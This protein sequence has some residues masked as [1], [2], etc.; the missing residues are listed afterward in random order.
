MT[1]T[2]LHTNANLFDFNF[3]TAWRTTVISGTLPAFHYFKYFTNFPISSKD[4]KIN[5][6][7][8]LVT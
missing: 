8:Q 3:M 5:I 6:S 2:V 1:L 7:L 4:R